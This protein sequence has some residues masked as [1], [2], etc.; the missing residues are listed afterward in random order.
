MDTKMHPV[1]ETVYHEAVAVKT[2]DEE[3]S[4]AASSDEGSA[5]R[6]KAPVPVQQTQLKA[7]AP[8]AR[9]GDRDDASDS[10]HSSNS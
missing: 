9:M 3:A 6:V 7:V 5:L 8:A 2:A 4:T 1:S 10:G